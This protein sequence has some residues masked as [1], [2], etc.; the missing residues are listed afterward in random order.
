MMIID[1]IW[2]GVLAW[3]VSQVLPSE[4]GTHKPWYFVF[5]PSYW[6]DCLGIKRNNNVG[7]RISTGPDTVDTNNINVQTV[8]PVPD[9]LSR[10]V[11]IHLPITNIC[12]L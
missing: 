10:Q 6:M 2:M 3:Y 11:N 8:E 4:F 12:T 9:N 5:L 1:A 7:K